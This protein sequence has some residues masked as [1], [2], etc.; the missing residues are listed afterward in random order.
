MATV[1]FSTNVTFGVIR[2]C[3]LVSL[4]SVELYRIVPAISL[5]TKYLLCVSQSEV[6]SKS[7]WA[8]DDCH[9]SF[10]PVLSR[11]RLGISI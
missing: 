6:F 7:Q 9:A 8:V 4:D 5:I 2:A 1:I 10:A 3:G 11:I